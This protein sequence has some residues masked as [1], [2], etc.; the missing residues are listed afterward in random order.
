MN[1]QNEEYWIV[2]CPNW[3][4]TRSS[5]THNAIRGTL[6]YTRC[7]AIAALH[8][9]FTEHYTCGPELTWKWKQFYAKGYRCVRVAI[10][11]VS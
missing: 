7:G 4:R 6:A 10:E 5:S 3:W 9:Y 8:A 1:L 2:A 11:V